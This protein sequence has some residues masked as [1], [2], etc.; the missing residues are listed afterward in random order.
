[1]PS[2]TAAMRV[3]NAPT[4]VTTMQAPYRAPLRIATPLAVA[5]TLPP[6]LPPSAADPQYAGTY[7]RIYAGSG[8]RQSTAAGAVGTATGRPVGVHA[9]SVYFMLKPFENR[10]I[11]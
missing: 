1:M 8:V 11:C 5:A 9:T 3:R 4:T 7:L 6:A 10:I 2:A